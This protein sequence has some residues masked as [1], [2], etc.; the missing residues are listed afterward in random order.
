MKA[1]TKTLNKIPI[2]SFIHVLQHI[3]EEGAYFID[4]D[5][6]HKSGKENDIIKIT[7]RPEYYVSDHNELKQEKTHPEYLLTELKLNEQGINP[8]YNDDDINDLI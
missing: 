7:V 8:I 3:Y 4:I 1:Q 2:L 6:E 5:G